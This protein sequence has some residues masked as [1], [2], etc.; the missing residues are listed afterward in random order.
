ME[1]SA[2][3]RQAG[4][5]APARRKGVG[6]LGHGAGGGESEAG[7]VMLVG[8][9]GTV[10][11]TGRWGWGESEPLAPGAIG[12]QGREAGGGVLG[13]RVCLAERGSGVCPGSDQPWAG[14]FHNLGAWWRLGRSLHAGV[15]SGR[16]GQGSRATGT[17][18]PLGLGLPGPRQ[19]RLTSLP[20][21][22]P[23]PGAPRHWETQ[24]G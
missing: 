11:A 13:F 1:V 10:G 20:Q 17:R 21:R 15:A 8:C 19:V 6:S 4:V 2:C 9:L 23:Q 18:G 7:S 22:G 14:A 3:G 24:W 16:P 5:G 12:F